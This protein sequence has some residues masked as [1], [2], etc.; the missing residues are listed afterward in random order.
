MRSTSSEAE[1]R[2]LTPTIRH[3]VE[4][5]LHV[6]YNRARRNVARKMLRYGENAA[7]AALPE[8]CP[9]TLEQ[10]LGDWEPG[11]AGEAG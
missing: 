9:I 8:V 2:T 6:I 3:H 4:A 1:S 7:A 11:G 10:V 5:E